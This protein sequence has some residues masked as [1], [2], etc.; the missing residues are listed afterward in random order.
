M[1]TPKTHA[2]KKENMLIRDVKMWLWLPT[3][4]VHWMVNGNL[5]DPAAVQGAQTV[6]TKMVLTSVTHLQVIL[7]WSVG[8]MYTI[9]VG[10]SKAVHVMIRQCKS[11]SLKQSAETQE[12]GKAWYT[13]I[14]R[15]ESR[16]IKKQ[17]GP[18]M[19]SSSTQKGPVIAFGFTLRMWWVKARLLSERH[20]EG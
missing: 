18:W 11:E 8:L 17:G 20:K 13:L 19:H 15:N 4:A 9:I 5:A 7:C 3:L 2:L 1:D 12:K 16:G 14:A 6:R 10:G